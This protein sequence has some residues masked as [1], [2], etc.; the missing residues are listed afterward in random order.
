LQGLLVLLMLALPTDKYISSMNGK[1]D[2]EAD[3]FSFRDLISTDLLYRLNSTIIGC[4]FGLPFCQLLQ[5][6]LLLFLFLLRK[7]PLVETHFK[8]L[9]LLIVFAVS[10]N[11]HFYLVE[12]FIR[13]VFAKG[14]HI[15]VV[16]VDFVV[17]DW[18]VRFIID[19]MHLLD[20]ESVGPGDLG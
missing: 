18:L 11:S 4:V 19:V 16:F 14:L 3:I 8:A 7:T 17:R 6:W 1:Y 10:F 12:H 15:T 5:L 13:Q 2:W 9:H 20:F